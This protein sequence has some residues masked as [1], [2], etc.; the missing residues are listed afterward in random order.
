MSSRPMRITGFGVRL[1]YRDDT[2]A[3]GLDDVREVAARLTAGGI[4]REVAPQAW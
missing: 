3:A 4:L 2:T 1:V